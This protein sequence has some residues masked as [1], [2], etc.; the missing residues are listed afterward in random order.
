MFLSWLYR[1]QSL[2]PVTAQNSDTNE[3][4]KRKIV[5]RLAKDFFEDQ[6]PYVDVG[7][8]AAATYL[9][10]AEFAGNCKNNWG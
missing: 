7:A 10:G 8:V 6:T 1:A 2:G 5:V 4:S 9:T 3:L